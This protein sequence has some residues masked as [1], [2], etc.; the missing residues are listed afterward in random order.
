ML[1]SPR[2]RLVLRSPAAANHHDPVMTC[3]LPRSDTWQR[4]SLRRRDEEEFRMRN[5]VRR[6]G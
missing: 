3:Y 4:A 6:L 2:S 5:N 1:A